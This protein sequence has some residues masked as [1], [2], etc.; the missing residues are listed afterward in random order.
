MNLGD[1]SHVYQLYPCQLISAE[2]ADVRYQVWHIKFDAIVD[3]HSF[4]GV[5][6]LKSKVLDDLIFQNFGAPGWREPPL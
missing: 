5:P 6:D 3:R 4:M 2:M 1:L